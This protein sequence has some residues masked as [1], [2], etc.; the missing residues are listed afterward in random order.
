MKVL[1]SLFI[2]LIFSSSLFSQKNEEITSAFITAEKTIEV[3]FTVQI[4]KSKIKILSGEESVT[5]NDVQE[6]KANEYRISTDK[7]LDFTKRYVVKVDDYE[8]R[9][10]PHWKAI[11]KLYT[12]SGELGSFYNWNK[13][14][15]KLWAPLASSVVLN[16]YSK[17]LDKEPYQTIS[18][19]R[20]E[21]GVWHT[22]VP[23]NLKGKYYTYSVTNYGVTKEVL[24]PYAKSM[25][26]TVRETFFTPKGAIVDQSSTGPNLD[27][28]EIEGYKKRED[29]I[30]WEAHVWDFT[31]DPDIKTKAPYGTY[32]AFSE[33]LDYIKDLGVTHIQLLPVLSY[34]YSDEINRDRNLNYELGANYNWGYGPDN[35][36]SP[37]GMYSVDP[38][39]PELR[40]KELKE[41]IKSIHEKGMGVTLDVVYNHTARLEFLEDIVPGYYH[42]MD[43]RG[44]AK[45]SYGGGRPGSTHA[46]ARKLIV[47]SILYWTK[48]YKV[49]GFRFDL[50]GDLDGETIQILYDEA[51][52]MNPD[53]L[54]VGECWR[55][56][57]G[58]DRESVI[59]ADQDWMNQ[60]NSVVCFSDEIR[61]ELKSGHGIEGEPRFVTG[62]ERSI[63]NIFNNVIAKPENMTEDDPGDVLQYVAVHDGL[64]LHDM[65][66]YSIKKD[67]KDHQEEIHKRIRLANTIILTSQGAAFLHAGQEYGRT[68]QWFS[69]TQPEREFMKVDEFE[70][71]YLIRNSY[72]ASSAVNMFDWD[73]VTNEG[74]HKSTMEYTSGLVALRRSTDAFRLGNEKLVSENVAL[75]E[76][77]DIKEE[78]LVLIFKAESTTNEIYYVIVNADSEQRTI[79]LNVDLT[80]GL[81]LVDSDE[82][83]TE[84]V[85]EVSGIQINSD[86][87]IVDPLTSVIIKAN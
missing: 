70:Y 77:K 1:Y 80:S 83:G 31:V 3:K 5:I 10:Q 18:L 64:T 54:M 53:I 37:E 21:K 27:F 28:A 34:T 45:Q 13:T 41:L 42:F 55:T 6:V 26:E 71:P 68:K 46:M 48:E 43:A 32:N 63:Q 73:K 57:A 78:D 20:K 61:N 50:M 85:S 66:A 8:R 7:V 36:F 17:G 40:I 82:A 19:N 49:D 72:D 15:F 51:K 25:A 4:D 16:L 58:D 75:I 30:I 33:R 69:S 44:V 35:Y 52:K 79:S 38:T 86:S 84:A 76:S 87:I 24:D 60:T 2:A 11:D 39:D 22:S 65:I 12:Y 62:G 81:V 9:A 67:P 56:F 29:A 59:P 23:G 74:I 47:D 14:D